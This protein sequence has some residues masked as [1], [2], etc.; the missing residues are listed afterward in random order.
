MALCLQ[1]PSAAELEEISRY[2]LVLN[3]YLENHFLKNVFLWFV[4]F[5]DPAGIFELVEVV[6]NGT[7]GQ[8]YKVGLAF[9][10]CII[11][12]VKNALMFY[13]TE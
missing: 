1:K 13:F 8:V 3:V 4:W 5:Q 6:G 7:Y 11:P 2:P 12:S 9:I 10:L